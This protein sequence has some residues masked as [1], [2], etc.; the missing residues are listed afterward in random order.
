MIAVG[1]TLLTISF[2]GSLAL[3]VLLYVEKKKKKNHFKIQNL[4]QIFRSLGS[5]V[6]T[7]VNQFKKTQLTEEHR[8]NW[9]KDI[10]EKLPNGIS[11][12]LFGSDGALLQKKKKLAEE[13]MVILNQ[14]YTLISKFNDKQR[15]SLYKNLWKLKNELSA[16]KF[17][18]DWELLISKEYD[19]KLRE[20]IPAKIRSKTPEKDGTETKS[21]RI[22]FLTSD[23]LD[24]P[25]F[26][27]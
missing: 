11:K 3:T 18:Q 27:R 8:K 19:L 24:E 1:G 21:V 12:A 25:F 13:K 9:A 2:V 5:L 4:P 17:N 6:P 10:I 20:P 22:K 14:F 23:A 7:L 26:L 15:L 16:F